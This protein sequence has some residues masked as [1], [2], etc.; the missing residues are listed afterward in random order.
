MLMT[1]IVLQHSYGFIDSE[2]QKDGHLF[3]HYSEVVG[4]DVNSLAIGGKV[5]I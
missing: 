5:L 3:F 2:V 4:G 1:F